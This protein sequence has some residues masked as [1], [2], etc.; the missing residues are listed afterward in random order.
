MPKISKIKKLTDEEIINLMNNSNS[1][2]EVLMKIG[3]KSTNGSGAYVTIKNECF[4]RNI[5]IPVFD[6]KYKPIKQI[7]LSND[8]VFCENSTYSRHHLKDR[9]IKEKLIEY[10]CSKCGNDG[11]WNGEKLSL[12]L[13]HINGISNDNRLENLTFL[14][15]NC[16]SQT[17]T[18]SGKKLKKIYYCKCGN[19]I[20][21]G[22][23]Q[24]LKCLHKKQRKVKNR[25]SKEQ[26]IKEI[27]ESSYVQVGKK[28][29]VSD[30]TIRKWL[31]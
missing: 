27:K 21:K 25:P 4:N 11:I 6:Y 12:Q 13:E 1:L 7:R 14:C 23:K 26:L 20:L 10:K 9:I 2:R 8:D 30:N 3:Y 16:H 29:G 24:C 17:K 15:P 31:K 28:Y 5:K 19:E 22:S 18:F